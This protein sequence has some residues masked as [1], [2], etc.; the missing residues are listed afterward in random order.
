MGTL[1]DQVR[2]FSPSGKR[3]EPDSYTLADVGLEDGDII[4]VIFVQC[5][6]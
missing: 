5:G 2:F 6:D 3:I 1:R 4:D